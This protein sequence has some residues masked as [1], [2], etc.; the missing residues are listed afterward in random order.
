MVQ[1][2]PFLA[3]F[4]WQRC[5]ER[6]R[7][8][9]GFLGDIGRLSVPP[10]RQSAQVRAPQ[11]FAVRVRSVAPGAFSL[12]NAAFSGSLRVLSAARL[13]TRLLPRRKV[14]CE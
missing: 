6:N 3:T 7:E 13:L 5:F 10:I 1:I 2:S 14:R 4:F 9:L 12:H 8:L 11:V